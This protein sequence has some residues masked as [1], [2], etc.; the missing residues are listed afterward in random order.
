MRPI[1]VLMPLMIE[2]EAIGKAM[3]MHDVVSLAMTPV[4]TVEL[5]RCPHDGLTLV[6]VQAHRYGTS[7]H[8]QKG[9]EA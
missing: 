1:P 5:Q 2:P 6:V 8:L 4:A 9:Q 7:T 3:P